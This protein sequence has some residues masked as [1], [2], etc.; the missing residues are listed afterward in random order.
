[1]WTAT[2]CIPLEIVVVDNPRNAVRNQFFNVVPG[3][4]GNYYFYSIIF[5]HILNISNQFLDPSIFTP[6]PECS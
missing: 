3:I 6:R 2:A 5:N 1:V 4:A